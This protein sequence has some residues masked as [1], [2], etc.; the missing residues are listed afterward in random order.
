[1]HWLTD[2]RRS[3]LA[4]EGMGGGSGWSGIVP[5]GDLLFAQALFVEMAI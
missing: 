4:S 1:M 3:E 5:L 2:F